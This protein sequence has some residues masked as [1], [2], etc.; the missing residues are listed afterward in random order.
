MSVQ[1]KVREG[2]GLL[3]KT[4]QMRK[5]DERAKILIGKVVQFTRENAVGADREEAA[6]GF[7]QELRVCKD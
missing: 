2:V 1:V 7:L 3:Q 4:T 5:N 6:E